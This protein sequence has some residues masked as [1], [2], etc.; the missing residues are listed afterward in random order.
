MATEIVD[1]WPEW[2]RGGP[3]SA[4]TFNYLKDRQK[5]EVAMRNWLQERDYCADEYHENTFHAIIDLYK[6]INRETR[7]WPQYPIQALECIHE[8]NAPHGGVEF[9][10]R[11]FTQRQTDSSERETQTFAVDID[12]ELYLCIANCLSYV[13]KDRLGGFANDFNGSVPGFHY[14]CK[15]IVM[16]E[17]RLVGSIL[18]PWR[19]NALPTESVLS[20]HRYID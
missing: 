2:K 4:L 15:S 14:Y 8:M 20:D 5:T 17:P 6:R 3:V 10:N 1:S 7:N 12:D 9:T 13:S 18:I 19:C 16:Q 11:L